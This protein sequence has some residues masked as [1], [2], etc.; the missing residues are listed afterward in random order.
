M[1][2]ISRYERSIVYRP[3]ENAVRLLYLLLYIVAFDIHHSQ[4]VLRSSQ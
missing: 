1:K 4:G 2:E 3:L